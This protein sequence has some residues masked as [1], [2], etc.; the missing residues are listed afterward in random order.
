MH[1]VIADIHGCYD[2]YLKMLEKI[3]F[4]DND[5][6]YFLGDAIDR[7]PDGIKVLLDMMARKT[8]FPF[9]AIMRICSTWSSAASGRS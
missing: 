6:L 9:G 2:L 8:L 5:T 3:G 1:Y 7:G 4:S